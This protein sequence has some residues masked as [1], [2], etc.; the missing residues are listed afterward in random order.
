M[1]KANYEKVNQIAKSNSIIIHHLCLDV[2]NNNI[3]VET[4]GV[5]PIISEKAGSLLKGKESIGIFPRDFIPLVEGDQIKFIFEKELSVHNMEMPEWE[6]EGLK[7]TPYDSPFDVAHV[8]IALEVWEPG[9]TLPLTLTYSTAL[10]KRTSMELF[11]TFFREAL[12]TVLDN[13]GIKLKDIKIARDLLPTQSDLY[14]ETQT[15]F[16]F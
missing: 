13:P 12:S 2:D 7:F 6:I 5:P 9:E 14:R 10:F 3:K 1:L 4:T 15:D 16:E 8:D 11:E